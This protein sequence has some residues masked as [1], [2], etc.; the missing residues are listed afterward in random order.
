[1]DRE[2]GAAL[3][4][5]KKLFEWLDAEGA[6]VQGRGNETFGR[7]SMIFLRW[8]DMDARNEWERRLED[9]GFEVER[10]YWPGNPVSQIQVSYFK[11]W[12]WNE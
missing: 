9:A 10:K 2:E 3:K 1:M 7:E 12:H 5:K 8:P 11:G 4:S 6:P